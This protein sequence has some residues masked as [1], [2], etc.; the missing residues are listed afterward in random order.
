MLA[1][2]QRLAMGRTTLVVAH[3][4]STVVEADRIVVLRGGRIEAMGTHAELLAQGGYYARLFSKHAR[5]GQAEA[6]VMAPAAGVAQPGG[7]CRSA[8]YPLSLPRHGQPRGAAWCRKLRGRGEAAAASTA[9]PAVPGRVAA[10][11]M[12]P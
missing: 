10:R 1:A 4:L 11:T 2:L 7:S 5:S 3:R 9:M 6:R 12:G 8:G